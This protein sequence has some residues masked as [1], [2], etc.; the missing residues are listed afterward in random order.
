[1]EHP[2]VSAR[3]RIGAVVVLIGWLGQLKHG[4]VISGGIAADIARSQQPCQRLPGVV[5]EGDHEVI[6]KGAFNVPAACSLSE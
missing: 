6:A 2:A 3:I 1:M 5:A 4:D